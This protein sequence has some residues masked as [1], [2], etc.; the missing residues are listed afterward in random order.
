MASEKTK[1][2][3]MINNPLKCKQISELLLDKYGHYIQPIN[4]PTVPRGSERLRVTPGPLHTKKMIDNLVN[5]LSECIIFY[6]V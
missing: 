4:Y 2:E 1:T 6:N 5:A 3:M